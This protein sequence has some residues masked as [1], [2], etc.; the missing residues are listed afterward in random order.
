MNFRFHFEGQQPKRENC[1]IDDILET[2]S[3][4]M[5][6][7]SCPLPG[8]DEQTT[9]KSQLLWKGAEIPKAA[10]QAPLKY[11]VRGTGAF[12]AATSSG[13]GHPARE[14]ERISGERSIRCRTGRPNASGASES[15]LMDGRDIKRER[16]S[17]FKY[18]HRRRVLHLMSF[19]GLSNW[20]STCRFS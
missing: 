9:D 11:S 19:L 12:F 16:E 2:S 20:N 8:V 5:I 4:I 3:R 7:R 10:P 17:I 15:N 14:Q 18:W 13:E 1:L 6:I